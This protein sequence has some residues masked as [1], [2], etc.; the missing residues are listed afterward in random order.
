[1][2]PKRG[3]IPVDTGGIDEDRVM[4]VALE[5][6]AD[7]VADAGEIFE[8]ADHAGEFEEVRSALEKARIT[9]ASAE[10]TMMPPNTVHVDRPHAGAA[11]EAAR[12]A[13]GSRRRAERVVEH[14]HRAGEARAAVRRVKRWTSE[15]RRRVR[16]LGIDPGTAVT[17]WGVV[18]RRGGGVSPPRERHRRATRRGCLSARGSRRIHAA[19][20]DLCRAH[21][22]S[23]VALERAFVARN[24]QSAFRLG[25][26]R[27]AVLVAAARGR[28]CRSTSTRPRR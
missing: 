17:G 26:V 28:H 9:L 4:E 16:V 5:A 23:S 8:V 14:G 7:D 15:I 25:E 18:E 13:R 24:V 2:F 6:G 20:A 1:M 27:G 10:V 11:A 22:R 3:M 19:V 12:G 21:A